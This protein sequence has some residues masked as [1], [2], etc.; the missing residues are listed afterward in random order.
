MRKFVLTGGPSGGKTSAL[1]ILAAYLTKLGYTV[2]IVEET[3]SIILAQGGSPV[4]DGIVPFQLAIAKYQEEAENAVEALALSNNAVNPIMLLDRGILDNKAYCDASTWIEVLTQF[5]PH[6]APHVTEQQLYQRYEHVIHLQTA[7]RINKYNKD[8]NPNRYETAE[9]AIIRDDH[10][11]RAWLPHHGLK[12]V[13]N[14]PEYE[15]KKDALL[16]L[17]NQALGLSP[18]L[19][20][21]KKFLV[22]LTGQESIAEHLNHADIIYE[23]EQQYIGTATKQ[24]RL[25]K[26]E[27]QYPKYP[28]AFNKTHYYLTS[29]TDSKDPTVREEVETEISEATYN[30]LSDPLNKPLKKTR[31]VTVDFGQKVEVDVIPNIAGYPN[32]LVLMELEINHAAQSLT[33]PVTLQHAVDVTADKAYNNFQLWKRLNG[34]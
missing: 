3:A 27:A 16:T 6:Q 18:N 17:I 5:K 24:L 23:I 11:I 32:P 8:N 31:Y 25:R 34:Q 10:T 29:K 1:K 20:I 7:A 30:Q 33:L 13:P 22:P 12:I 4:K 2:F 9:E 28:K 19:E 21:E 14:F 15:G 26:A